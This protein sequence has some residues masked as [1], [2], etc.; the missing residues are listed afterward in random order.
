MTPAGTSNELDVQNGWE[1]NTTHTLFS[2]LRPD[3][4]IT[5]YL[6][7]SKELVTQSLCPQK[8]SPHV[9]I[10]YNSDSEMLWQHSRHSKLL[11]RTK[12]RLDAD[13]FPMF[14]VR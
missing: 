4:R 1:E 5:I 14:S 12:I 7:Q 11:V 3:T 9:A 10:A 2:T 6:V 8:S 13:K